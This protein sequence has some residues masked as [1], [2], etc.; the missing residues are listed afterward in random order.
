[1]FTQGCFV[2][3]LVENSPVVLE[4]IFKSSKCIFTIFQLSPPLRRMWPFIWPNLNPLHQ[5]ILR[6]KFGLN[7]PSGSGEVDFYKLSIHFWYFP[8]ISP[9]GRAWPTFVQTWIPFTQRYFV[10]R[11]ESCKTIIKNEFL[12][13]S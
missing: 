3:S 12:S 2:P 13:C 6:A 4:K 7:W 11:N 1:M 10:A 9:L 8:I 5:R